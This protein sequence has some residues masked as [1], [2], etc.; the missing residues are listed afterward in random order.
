[1][2]LSDMISKQLLH[3]TFWYNCQAFSESFNFNFLQ[4]FSWKHFLENL[5][6]DFRLPQE[7]NEKHYSVISECQIYILMVTFTCNFL[8][9]FPIVKLLVKLLILNSYNFFFETFFGKFLLWFPIARNLTWIFI[10]WFPIVKFI[11]QLL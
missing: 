1:M 5:F 7:F 4:N 3:A 8:M 6:C 10:A 9:W 11:S 2:Q